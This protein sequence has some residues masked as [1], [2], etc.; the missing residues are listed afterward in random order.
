MARANTHSDGVNGG[1]VT[2]CTVWDE[3]NSVRCR[4]LENGV[5]KSWRQVLMGDQGLLLRLVNQWWGRGDGG[6]WH[7]NQSIL[8]A[9]QTPAESQ[10]E[11]KKALFLL[12]FCRGT[13]NYNRERERDVSKSE[14][15]AHGENQKCALSTAIQSKSTLVETECVSRQSPR[16]ER[17]QPN[18]GDKSQNFVAASQ[19]SDP[20]IYVP[21][22][23]KKQDLKSDRLHTSSISIKLSHQSFK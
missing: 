4:E 16:A 23:C 18:R 3:M 5:D 17:M 8:R 21:N 11:Q 14:N 1:W 13:K 19:I 9:Q 2:R 20:N 6:G 15:K 10:T 7:P 12:F 22:V